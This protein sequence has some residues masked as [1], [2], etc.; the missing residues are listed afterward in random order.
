MNVTRDIVKDLLTVY[1]AG[2]ASADTRTLV[3]EWLRTDPELAR[4]AQQARSIDLPVT[5]ALPRTT[6]K[7]ALDRTRRRLRARTVLFGT[8][9][10]V[11]TLPL[12]VTFG[13]NGFN[14]LLIDNWP[15]RWVVL[16]I[17]AMLWAFYVR[18]AR[19][20]RVSGL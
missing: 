8:A 7:R 4:H 6:E 15:E 1:L 19:R 12:S 2:E 18:A 10:Y 5:P 16:A 14:G 9:V 17:A 13:K 20:A 3:E 11:T